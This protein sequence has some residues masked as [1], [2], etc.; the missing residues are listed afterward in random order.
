MPK[1]KTEYKLLNHT[2]GSDFLDLIPKVKA[3]QAKINGTISNKQTKTFCTAKE[4]INK[5]KRHPT[6]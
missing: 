1:R 6:K 5:V 4:T 2:L 3:I